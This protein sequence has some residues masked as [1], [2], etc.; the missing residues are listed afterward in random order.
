VLVW[1]DLLGFA[2]PDHRAPKFVRAYA[3]LEAVATE[4]IERFCADVRAGTYPASAETYHMTDRMADA[5][6]LYGGASEPELAQ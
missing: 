1:H 4:A 5:L 3:A 6:G 2:G